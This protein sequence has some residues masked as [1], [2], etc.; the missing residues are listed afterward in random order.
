M[1]GKGF[2]GEL[3]ESTKLEI[4][5]ASSSS[6]TQGS[7]RFTGYGS[8]GLNFVG[9]FLE[10]NLPPDLEIT[11]EKSYYNRAKEF[12]GAPYKKGG[13]DKDGIDCSGLVTRSSG[14]SRRWT[15]RQGP[16][17][18]NWQKPIEG[19]TT[20]EQ[21]LSAIEEGDLLVW[22]R[23]KIG[24]T[25]SGGHAAFYAGKGK[26]FHAHGEAGTPTGLTENLESYW[27]KKWGFP[28]VYRQVK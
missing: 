14:A 3:L 4:L 25:E 9:P 19:P 26:L 21:F 15:T 1:P 6:Q 12:E 23:Q 13:D 2:L 7:K 10:K 22:P 18:G 8:G 24:K 16:P 17:P 11:K 20:K 28:D 27:L 5:P